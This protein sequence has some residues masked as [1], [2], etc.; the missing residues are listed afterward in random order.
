MMLTDRE[1]DYLRALYEIIEKK[2]YAKVKN[3]A[4]SLDVTPASVVGMMKKL[5]KK[6]LIIYKKW[7]SIQLTSEGKAHAKAIYNR[8]ETFKK[9]LK[10]INV[11]DNVA[12]K[13][14]HILEH[15]LDV[16][17]INQFNRFVEL[18]NNPEKHNKFLTH[19][20]EILKDLM[21]QKEV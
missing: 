15:H 8:H 6:K 20:S 21:T 14:A 3:V 4:T 1:E 18:I 13:D 7:E 16:I 19:Y 2:G 5:S 9:F 12:A 11:P 10:I 17:T